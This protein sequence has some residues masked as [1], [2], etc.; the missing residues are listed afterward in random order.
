M[1]IKKTL[2]RFSDSFADT[3]GLEKSARI[4][5]VTKRLNSE[6]YINSIGGSLLY[7]KDYF[8]SQGVKLSFLKPLPKPYKQSGLGS[9]VT[10]L[11][12]IDLIMRVETAMIHE[13]LHSF[14]L[15]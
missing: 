12:I 10:N 13:H 3:K 15:E 8:L 9:F 4:I 6:H 14:E 5:E 2:L 11:S 7:S 1:G